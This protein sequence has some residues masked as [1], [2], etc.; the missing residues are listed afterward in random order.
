MK[1]Y[2]SVMRLLAIAL[3]LIFVSACSTPEALTEHREFVAREVVNNPAVEEAYIEQGDFRLYY[4]SS[5]KAEDAVAV[6]VH[7][8]PGGWGSIG[9]LL[10]ND[11]FNSRVLLASI[12]RPGWGYSQYTDEPRLVTSY[13]EQANLIAPLLQKLK[14]DH[15]DKP[16]ILVGHSLGGSIIPA[17]A[18]DF[19]ELVDGLL[20]LSAGLNPDITGPRWYNHMAK[21]SL[22]NAALDE[23]MQAANVEMFS[24]A[25]ELEKLRERW[26]EFEMPILVVQGTEDELVYPANA[27]FAES[28]LNSNNSRVVRLPNQGHFVHMER[29]DLIATCVL[30]IAT[31]QLDHCAE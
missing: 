14:A 28:V 10:V 9:R 22:I 20:I 21:F 6:W 11:E 30:A 3:I 24:L 27:D 7:G 12:D 17:I 19:P 16:L 26:A 1:L 29:T 13:A 18:A 2:L 5:G 23:R 31:E 25:I 8:T 4:R 15:P